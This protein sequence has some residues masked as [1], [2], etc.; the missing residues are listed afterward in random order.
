MKTN[1]EQNE[2]IARKK[3]PIF[4]QAGPGSGKTATI[5]LRIQRLI[6]KKVDPSSILLLSYTKKATSELRKRAKICLGNED[7]QKLTW[8]TTFHKLSLTILR[9]NVDY[10]N[11][12]K[13]GFT[14]FSTSMREMVEDIA[15][16]KKLKTN[17]NTLYKWLFKL[18]NQSVSFDS[19]A[20]EE[21]KSIFTDW[22]EIDAFKARLSDT[23]Y[24]D[25]CKILDIYEQLLE[26]KNQIDFIGMNMKVLQLFD[27]YPRLA[28]IYQKRFQ[29]IIVDEFQDCT[30][31]QYEL[32]KAICNVEENIMVVGDMDQMIY[33]YNGSSIQIPLRFL[34]DFPNR[35]YFTLSRN[36]RSQQKIVNLANKFISFNSDWN[37]KLMIAACKPGKEIELLEGSTVEEETEKILKKM[38]ELVR[39]DNRSFSEIAILFRKNKH[40]ACL[41]QKMFEQHIL[42]DELHQTTLVDEP[43]VKI[44]VEYFHYLKNIQ[45]K[46][47]FIAI[48]NKPARYIGENCLKNLFRD[49]QGEELL[50]YIKEFVLL[51]EKKNDK[52]NRKEIRK[53]SREGL[54]SFVSLIEGLL[55]KQNESL[56][57]QV[58]FLVTWIQREMMKKEEKKFDLAIRNEDEQLS[59]S[60]DQE[61]SYDTI[62]NRKKDRLRLERLVELV[63]EY[64]P[65]TIE[66]FEKTLSLEMDVR[67][68]NAVNLLTIHSSKGMEFPIVFVIGM[69]E[70]IFYQGMSQNEEILMDQIEEERRVCY[71]GMT[72]AKEELYFSYFTSYIDVHDKVRQTE[73]IHFLNEMGL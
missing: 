15:T 66:E 2:V 31:I 57:S 72:R 71:V 11:G 22:N 34:H 21:N 12:L 16:Q 35:L 70:G 53:E 33:G 37:R 20:L 30:H 48:C 4:V 40:A 50:Q 29:Y 73:R 67:V 55:A 69:S 9:E 64:Q 26:Q 61:V 41:K 56:A 28:K 1:S 60:S 65:N 24:E 44:V 5:M 51:N 43:I 45:N 68:E 46:E 62:L 47:G 10:V 18:R 54:L 38:D 7:E 14:V 59:H 25:L 6:Q 23:E 58:T 39:N 49:Y 8:I 42:Y 17:A 19:F 32:L 27:E 13:K 52:Y 3:G 36:Y 63:N